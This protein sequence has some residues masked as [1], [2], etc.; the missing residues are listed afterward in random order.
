MTLAE[1]SA[2]PS[3]HKACVY[4]KPGSCAIE[5]RDVPTPEPG[6]GEVLVKLTHSGICHSDY[7]VM[8]SSVREPAAR[9]A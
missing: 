7:S 3:T 4:S 9:V 1:A 6:P 2:I 8:M 5:I